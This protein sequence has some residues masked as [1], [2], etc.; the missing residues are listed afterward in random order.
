M[1]RELLTREVEEM[2]GVRVWALIS[3]IRTR[4]IDPAPRKNVSGSFV[5][6]KADIERAREALKTYRPRKYVI[7]AQPVAG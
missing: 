1:K 5:W 3:L 6:S 4:R 2:L 7:G